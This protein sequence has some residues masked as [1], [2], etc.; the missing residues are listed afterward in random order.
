MWHQGIDRS[1]EHV[2]AQLG[3]L[4]LPLVFLLIGASQGLGCWSVRWRDTG[5]IIWPP[6]GTGHWKYYGG[7]GCI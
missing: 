4:L 3:D 7:S 6:D 5:Q 1:T 2:H